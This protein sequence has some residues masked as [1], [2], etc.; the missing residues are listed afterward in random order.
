M[1]IRQFVGL[2]GGRPNLAFYFV[3]CKDEEHLIYLDPHIVQSYVSDILK[4]YPNNLHKFHTKEARCIN[5]DKLDPCLG[6]GFLI[7]D[8]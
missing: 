6:F 3:G 2:I 5:M 4:K 8:R 1:K 7:K